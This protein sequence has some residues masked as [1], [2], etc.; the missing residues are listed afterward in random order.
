[1]QSEQIDTPS[2]LDRVE[3]AGKDFNPKDVPPRENRNG[4]G[5]A[6]ALASLRRL[7]RDRAKARPAEDRPS[8]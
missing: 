2:Q 8:G 5:A 6:S 3:L 7:E 4:E 1:M